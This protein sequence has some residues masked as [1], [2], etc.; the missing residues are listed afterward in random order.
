MT[1][2]GFSNHDDAGEAGDASDAYFRSIFGDDVKFGDFP[3]F[4]DDGKRQRLAAVAR[5]VAGSSGVAVPDEA[6]SPDLRNRVL[7]SVRSEA[8]RLEATGPITATEPGKGVQAPMP[9]ATAGVSATR[10]PFSLRRVR[11]RI[12][13]MLVALVAAI[14]ALFSSFGSSPVVAAS[15]VLAPNPG[16]PSP[17]AS[18][19]V[20]FVSP[21]KGAEVDKV[22]MTVEGLTPNGS[23]TEYQCWLVGVGDSPTTPKRI[24]VGTFKTKDG[25]A[26]LDWKAAGYSPEFQQ[27]DVS[28][29]KSDGNPEY[30]GVTVLSTVKYTGK[31]TG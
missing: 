25:S 29:E 15:A 22:E 3:E 11:G 12:I 5:H 7:Q 21:K 8:G 2:E 1:N 30:G 13:A 17:L 27:L 9:T 23:D 14:T 4:A 26:K 16:S 10:P 31:R 28:L 20:D 6:P 19:S 18:G 24:L